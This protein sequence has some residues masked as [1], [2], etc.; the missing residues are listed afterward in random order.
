MSSFEDELLKT[1]MSI[2]ASQDS[3]PGGEPCSSAS[4]NT[5]FDELSRFQLPAGVR[6]VLCHEGVLTFSTQHQEYKFKIVNC[7]MSWS[8]TNKPLFCANLLSR[9]ENSG[10][11]HIDCPSLIVRKGHRFQ[12]ED[13]RDSGV[14]RA[15][16]QLFPTGT[17]G[18]P[19]HTVVAAKMPNNQLFLFDA[20]QVQ[21][22]NVFPDEL[23]VCVEC[24]ECW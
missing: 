16:S 17:F 24:L 7:M 1:Y 22:K 11:G 20:S 23:I 5:L 18:G 21:F 12:L 14:W 2:K 9:Q 6:R 19:K 15:D 3:L 10:Q 4:A 8:Q 13:Q